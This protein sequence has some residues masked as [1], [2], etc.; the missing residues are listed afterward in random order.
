M[1]GSR[2][3]TP[4]GNLLAWIEQC[5]TGNFIGAFVGEDAAPGACKHFSG[6]APATCLCSS[7][8]EARQWV[9]GQ[10][11]SFGLPVKWIRGSAQGQQ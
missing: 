2:F 5:D 10:A 3:V 11:A 8:S 4:N 6:R 1:R 7:A 9:E